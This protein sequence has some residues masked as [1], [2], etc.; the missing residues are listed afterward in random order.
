M[1]ADNNEFHI[2]FEETRRGV[3]SS[4]EEKAAL[5]R[6]GRYLGSRAIDRPT[7]GQRRRNR[8]GGRGVEIPTG[9]KP[10]TRNPTGSRRDVDGDGWA[11]EGTKRPVFVGIGNTEPTPKPKPQA[12][13]QTAK[14][15]ET[16]VAKKLS[17][18]LEQLSPLERYDYG[19]VV[20]AKKIKSKDTE[21]RLIV[22]SDFDIG[23]YLESD[24]DKARNTLVERFNK[25][26]SNPFNDKPAPLS[27]KDIDDR[28][29]LRFILDNDKTI[30]VMSA[31]QTWSPGGGSR[32][33][34]FQINTR[35]KHQRRGLAAEMFNTH[36]EIFPELD[37]QHSN[38][39]SED[40]R[41]FSKA[42]PAT[43]SMES[44][45]R[46]SSLS[47]GKK[48]Q[49]IVDS[50]PE[51]S[52]EKLRQIDEL[53][54]LL[55]SD[56]LDSVDSYSEDTD[57]FGAGVAILN[58]SP[59]RAAQRKRVHDL[60]REIFNGEI[61]LEEDIIVTATNG[62]KV[63][64][65]KTVVVEVIDS[66]ETLGWQV[67][68]REVSEN[69]IKKVQDEIFEP[70]LSTDSTNNALSARFQIK[71][72]ATPDAARQLLWEGAPDKMIWDEMT[73]TGSGTRR[74]VQFGRSTRMLS[75][76]P[77]EKPTTTM[78]HETFFLNSES[79]GHGI[80]SAFNARNEKIYEAIGQVKILTTGTSNMQ[81]SVGA[82]HWPRNGFT[83]AGEPGK[84][85]FL[86]TIV[87]ALNDTEQNWFSPEEKSRISSLI[88]ENP[89]TGLFE[90]DSTPENLLKFQQATKLF[91]DKEVS[92][93][94]V[95][96]VSERKTPAGALSSGRIGTVE[97]EPVEMMR[98]AE[99]SELGTKLIDSGG[100]PDP[101]SSLKEYM[102]FPVYEIDGKKFAFGNID[103]GRFQPEF[104]T[105]D[106]EIVPF[107]PYLIT[108]MPKTSAEGQEWALKMFHAIQAVSLLDEFQAGRVGNKKVGLVAALTYAAKRG[109]KPALEELE[110]LAK[111]GEELLV[112]NR[113]D[114]ISAAK[115]YN[116]QMWDVDAT[117]WDD[118]PSMQVVLGPTRTN[119]Y[120]ESVRV[121]RPLGIDD[122]FLVHQTSY[123]PQYDADGNI[124]LRPTGDFVPID[125]D[126]G[127][128][129]LDR[130]S[131]K[132]V[133]MPD[134]DT[135]HFTIN[136][137]V[138][139][140]MWRN[141]PTESTSVIVVPLRDVL[142]AN[143]GSLDNLFVIDT[144]LTPKPGEGLVIPMKN[145]KVVEG[146]GKELRESV[147][148]TLLEV[149]KLHN[150][151]PEYVT[152]TFLGGESYSET[153]DADNRVGVIALQDIP[154]EY[155]EYTEGV[156]GSPHADHPSTHLATYDN[157][158]V[159][160]NGSRMA[161]YDYGRLSTNAKLRIY[162][163]N[164]NKYTSARIETIYEESKFSS[165]K[166]QRRTPKSGA[167]L[168][169]AFDEPREVTYP[170]DP[171]NDKR[172]RKEVAGRIIEKIEE[173]TGT[174]LTTNQKDTIESVVPS[175]LNDVEQ[176]TL[177]D[178]E[179]GE[180]FS[181]TGEQLLS[182]IAI[183]ISSDGIPFVSADPIPQLAEQ[184]PDKRDWRTVE[185]PKRDDV[186]SILNEALEDTLVFKNNTWLDAD[187]NIVARKIDKD[188]GSSLEFE[189][190]E[191]RTRFPLLEMIAPSGYVI[192]GDSLNLPRVQQGT[193][194]EPYYEAWDK[195][196]KF[197]SELARRAGELMGDEELFGSGDKMGFITNSFVSAYVGG[198]STPFKFNMGLDGKALQYF[199]DLF[200]HMGTGRAFDRHGEWANDLAIMSIV[201]HP[202][203][204]LTPREKL[205]V[206]HLHYLL[207]SARR[208]G[209]GRLDEP[210]K[211]HIST[212]RAARSVFD[213]TYFNIENGSRETPRIYAGDFGSVIKK[214]D[215]AST[216]KGL[217]SGR[218]SIYEADPK[219]V[220]IALAYD[221]LGID[222]RLASGRE[223]PRIPARPILR[224]P[225]IESGR[226]AVKGYGQP[227]ASGKEVRRNSNKWL[228]GMTPEEISRVIVPTS[229]AEHF[230]MWADDMA[231]GSWK[232][233]SKER[234]FLQKYYDELR[235]NKNSLDIDYSP[236]NVKITQETVRGMLES[237]PQMLWMFENFG[238]PMIIS[239][240]REAVSGFENSP[241]MKERLELH[242]QQ[243]GTEK[244]QFIS[245]LS[246]PAFGLIGLSPRALID[247]E[248][249]T[250]DEKGVYPI[251][252]DP[253]RIPQPRDAHIDRSLHG[254]IV[255]EYGHWLHYRAAWDSEANGKTRKEKS[256][257]GSGDI[258][259]PLYS[260]AL[261]VADEY[262][263]PDTDNE[264]IQ[265]WSEFIDLTERDAAEMFGANR[266]KALTA[267]SYGNVNKREAIAEA[268][269]AIMHPN[270]DMPKLALS[271]KLRDDVYA[272]AGVDPNNLP[273]AARADG[274]PTIQLSSDVAP[275]VATEDA[276]PLI[277]RLLDAIQTGKDRPISTS[278]KESLSSGKKPHTPK[279]KSVE[280][281][282]D[283]A[284]VGALPDHDQQ[285]K[286][287]VMSESVRDWEEW[288][289]CRQIRMAAYELAGIGEYSDRDPNITKT[290]GF[291]GNSRYETVV[292]PETRTEQAR[293]IMANIVDSL[294]NKDKYDRQPY[295]YRAMT[296]SSPE[297][298]K[299]FF[300]AMQ[301]GAQVD[302]PLIAFVDKGPSPSGGHFLTKFGTDALLV[303]EDFPGAYKAEG[304]FE[305]L[306][307]NTDESDTLYNI[308]EF[309]ESILA[310]IE[311]G[312]IDEESIEFDTEF[313]NRLI[314]LVE[315]YTESRDPSER[316]R[317]K[318]EM[319]EALEETGNESIKL[320]WE[321]EPLPEDHE[322]Y[323]EAL[324]Y[325]ESLYDESSN[326]SPR[327]HISG[328]RL[329]V[330]SVE[331]D[332]A[333]LYKEVV[334]L[335]QIGAFD[336]QEK[337]ALVLKTDGQPRSATLSSGNRSNSYNLVAI[338][339][340]DSTP[341]ML[342][343]LKE[344]LGDALVG[345]ETSTVDL[346][347]RGQTN[348]RKKHTFTIS[349][350]KL[351]NTHAHNYATNR[352][353]MAQIQELSSGAKPPQ[354]PRK[355]TM[356]AF[357][358][359]ADSEFDGITN[360]EDFK[361]AV[362]DKEIV[363]I[364]YETTGLK[365]NE[366]NESA[367]NGLP[368]QI[369]A[370]KMKNGKVVER[371]NV[372]VNPGI[373]MSE[374]EKWSQDNLKDG[375]GNPITDAYLADKPSIAEAHKQLV[376]FM[377][378]TELMGM[379]NAVFDNEVLED[380]LKESGIEWRPKGIIDTK[381]VS[382]MVLPK[383]SETNPNAPFRVNK[384]GT[385]SPSN[386]LGDITKFL[387]VDLGD[388]HH[389]ADAD[390]EATAKVLQAIID[391][392]I[393]N[394]WPADV[395]DK[396]KR[397]D[398]ENKTQIK[399]EKAVSEFEDAKK[400]F[401]EDSGQAPLSSGKSIVRSDLFGSKER[402]AAASLEENIGRSEFLKNSGET[403]SSN[404]SS[405]RDKYKIAEDNLENIMDS[406]EL[407]DAQRKRVKDM[408]G[409]D[410]DILTELMK[411]IEPHES[412]S[413]IGKE[414]VQ[415]LSIQV[416]S[417]D[418]PVI[419]AEPN[420]IFNSIIPDR[421]DWRDVEAPAA[422]QILD[423]IEQSYGK[424]L[425]YDDISKIMGARNE[426]KIEAP[427]QSEDSMVMGN[428]LRGLIEKT[429]TLRGIKLKDGAIVD[430]VDQRVRENQTLN[431]NA[432]HGL[433][434]LGITDP[435]QAV[436]TLDRLE[437]QGHDAIGHLGTGR[438]FDRHG[439]W[440]NV[441]AV[442]S[443]FLDSKDIDLSEE[444][445]EKLARTYIAKFGFGQLVL[446]VESF[447][448]LQG[449]NR[450][451]DFIPRSIDF[452]YGEALKEAIIRHPGST[453]EM[454]KDLGV[455][456][457][458]ERASLS[459]GDT[460]SSGSTILSQWMDV[461]AS[462]SFGESGSE[463]RN[464]FGRTD[465]EKLQKVLQ[466]EQSALSKTIDEWQKTGVW[467]G[468]TNGVAMPRTQYPKSGITRNI[469]AEELSGMGDKDALIS[470]FNGYQSQIKK[471]L[472]HVNDRITNL[473]RMEN[474]GD[475]ANFN[476]ISIVDLP[477]FAALAERGKE[478]KN[479][480]GER[481]DGWSLEKDDPDATWLVHTGAPTLEN[482]VLDPSFTLPKGGDGTYGR[483][484]MD[485]QRLNS[486][487]R[488]SIIGLYENAE[489]DFN[490]YQLVLK[491]Y[492]E[493][494]VWDGPKLARNTMVPGRNRG[495]REFLTYTE[496]EDDEKINPEY[497]RDIARRYIADGQRVMARYAYAYP[498]AKAGKEH[499]S[500]SHASQGPSTGYVR[501]DAPT[502]KTY[503]V[504]IPN[505]EVVEGFP[506][507]EYQIFEAR[508]PIAS[509]EVP[510]QFNSPNAWEAQDAAIAL[511]EEVAQ[512]Y[513]SKDK[514][515]SGD[516][517]G[518]LLRSM[519]LHDDEFE[520]KYNQKVPD[521]DGDC[522]SKAVE[523]ARDL[524]ETYES[525]KIAHGY[526]LGTG[527]DAEG[528]RFPHAWNEFMRDGVEWVRDYSNGNEVEIP[529]AV[530]YAIGNIAEQDVS[531]FS[532]EEAEKSMSENGHYGP[533]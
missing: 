303:L 312:E 274:R 111:I 206:K 500:Y 394:G 308:N 351:R 353:F 201:D 434:L 359:S 26:G 127:E 165:G 39:L 343:S 32:T 503:L 302:I 146:S 63:N 106:I 315:D 413:D 319:G 528:L 172:I 362:A 369:G 513:I 191:A 70:F 131:G 514:L 485:T 112:N 232:T 327:E 489:R 409:K 435:A 88:R 237:S 512:K 408:F 18:G 199:H 231:G 105:K 75:Y 69:A 348:V 167:N 174:K 214:L 253:A 175:L 453:R 94:Y 511:F 347:T 454:L 487:T 218:K 31:M 195:H 17:S 97:T 134:R 523:Q 410:K 22:R 428:I 47:S 1:S 318:T 246:S 502:S 50:Q 398:K 16:E 421:R 307:N 159:N 341:E 515:S 4:T 239:F 420:P 520:K 91:K 168:A 150:Q 176:K 242:R 278:S 304:T 326:R 189:N 217:S 65:G 461:T 430:G 495:D 281:I 158:Y 245:G 400:A 37:L 358:G 98:S 522:F 142:D 481:R 445:R 49:E 207:Y 301:V 374:W 139:G 531:V 389:N 516:N 81:D 107:N 56:L 72:T 340:D 438:G 426:L 13:R 440:A 298:A 352:S 42:V 406:L 277:S 234:E 473:D 518:R 342:E 376:E 200:G 15:T 336:P 493:T 390:A 48:Y 202:D 316:R 276:R 478:I 530:Y 226:R 220:E 403:Q 161:A 464:T 338:E 283:Y 248:S 533:W 392:A 204:P 424:N 494:G 418:I 235:A 33:E 135:V 263:N 446:Q 423:F 78:Q 114:S 295:L 247:R 53:N 224:R 474:E 157:A 171:G 475:I 524:A 110:R 203:S 532:L 466:D 101:T 325:H 261:R 196:A 322:G 393:E 213:T 133:A 164:S 321:G 324:Y 517:A 129:M 291:F 227:D 527:G 197:L 483:Q 181:E 223:R 83:W 76:F 8:G 55:R 240:T 67:E 286:E 477:N 179:L 77:G 219:D 144:F 270:K 488:N 490:A 60:L 507:Q 314:K 306:F 285:Q 382:D 320:E 357:V 184:I 61:E 188:G 299:Q 163:S 121:T 292:S 156:L 432:F 460:L 377:G 486:I 384:D 160:M 367:G 498:L 34:V 74:E 344:K 109:D 57:V 268:F 182:S 216:T 373:P 294:L 166:V 329:E 450:D 92:I 444:D 123:K 416:T 269:V 519:Q 19:P 323:Y 229:Q 255:H 180:A 209:D 36:R 337:G 433:Y 12:Q 79:Q 378:D 425:P 3:D 411:E 40:G 397:R 297:E 25:L 228:S 349:S 356:G 365:F 497:L 210:E 396:G 149:G 90:T 82:T 311:R 87:K 43:S 118:T 205:A 360:W 525:I 417:N 145:G 496:G 250:T 222:D 265:I 154:K 28:D 310:G 251:N 6:L 260:D 238:S 215:A 147:H 510:N 66:F 361:S 482:G 275:G 38:A 190:E 125:P 521:G 169:D 350:E 41:A 505:T 391:G 476:A 46:P 225:P 73:S 282:I 187:G 452:G 27:P 501:N 266:D 68:I 9:G 193:L 113:R 368:T 108:G 468:E 264:A 52:E 405:G 399:F 317:L 44:P 332:P 59:E 93:L 120:N 309:A 258:N 471:Q 457:P 388:K 345:H 395:L 385:K 194:P 459:S 355:P 116:E 289:P 80:G 383:W 529:K 506:S 401:I 441:L 252:L 84:Q 447:K 372:F 173:K 491:E 504:R 451:E 132:P 526:P 178:V 136:H 267:T 62:E 152:N 414:L 431:T 64:L 122:M 100:I 151:H 354:Y 386:S 415:S 221:A 279:W 296:F 366:F 370:V 492:D 271:K 305:P 331:P 371:F 330:V 335:R 419:T 273:W 290:D 272:L 102:E 380:A 140:H 249:M 293:Y 465:L 480:R 58:D 463:L 99:F 427:S 346:G 422:T 300:D 262:M 462:D 334:T 254:V 124:I 257:Y 192:P 284:A 448:E 455:D 104:D 508:T 233:N 86:E 375:D 117:Y 21:Y 183:D 198:I 429:L 54:E 130:I 115:R 484:G 470:T 177:L 126:T 103:L 363:F 96:E 212:A 7:I 128:Q 138:T 379:Q 208:I 412:L 287:Q 170:A 479:A 333:G 436:Q 11:D 95:R 162:D 442:V 256:F 472:D 89:D 449:K 29:V 20:A 469:P 185:L 499:L 10:G 439:E 437:N 236:E 404:L 211:G 85:T 288:N 2:P 407:D 71:L 313:A 467:N 364:D 23:I 241:E 458:V 35:P 119:Q 137:M 51:L 14:R 244:P 402:F 509:F 24:F 153:P 155:P 456:T 141:E 280:D 186:I 339:T 148:D 443:V 387:G 45:D 5:G 30:K 259:D 230:E 328:G 143:P 381:E 243:R